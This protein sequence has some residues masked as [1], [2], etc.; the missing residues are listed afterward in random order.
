MSA[1]ANKAAVRQ[2]V[3]AGWNRGDFSN[4]DSIYAVDYTYN[5]PSAPP[6]PKGPQSIIS[7]VS[8]Y[9]AAFPDVRMTIE[10]MISEG[11]KVVWR[12]TVTGTHNGPL[13]GISASGKPVRLSGIVISRFINGKWSED[14][15][16]WDTLGMLQQV[17]A[18]P[19][20]N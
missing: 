20:P 10:D 19:V 13:M 12:W 9:R 2:W 3:E 1:E 5:D 15:S 16:N 14:W 11:D 6:L 8:T 17:G 4:I 7:V 18:V